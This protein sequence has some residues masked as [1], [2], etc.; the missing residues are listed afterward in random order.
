MGDIWCIWL[1][2]SE[3]LYLINILLICFDI[4]ENELIIIGYRIFILREWI[5]KLFGYFKGL[6][7]FYLLI[8]S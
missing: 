5:V 7:V 3:I 4:I 6:L 1:I 2:I 8:N